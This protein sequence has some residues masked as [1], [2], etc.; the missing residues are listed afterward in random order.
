[1][2]LKHELN[3]LSTNNACMGTCEFVG[4]CNHLKANILALKGWA[5]ELTLTDIANSIF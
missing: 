1:M 5:F 4:R 3:A 2:I